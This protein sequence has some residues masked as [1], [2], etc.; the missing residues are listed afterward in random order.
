[1]KKV[2]TE[3]HGSGEWAPP[4]SNKPLDGWQV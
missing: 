3:A 1:V 4:S 2:L